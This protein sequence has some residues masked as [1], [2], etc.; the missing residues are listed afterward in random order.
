MNKVPPHPF[1]AK[2]GPNTRINYRNQI[3]TSI[4]LMWLV[5]YVFLMIL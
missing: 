4:T 5:I 3:Q 1:G 2:K